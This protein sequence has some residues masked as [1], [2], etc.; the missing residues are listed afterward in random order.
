[1]A[2]GGSDAEGNT[3]GFVAGCTDWLRC[4]FVTGDVCHPGSSPV[5]TTS[6]V[7]ERSGD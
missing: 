6:D 4:A 3:V 2:L 5:V 7:A 1:M